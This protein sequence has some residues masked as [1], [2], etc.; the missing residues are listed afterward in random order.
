MGAEAPE[1]H[2]EKCIKQHVQ[3]VTKN[4][5]FPLNQMV[6]NQY[7]AGTVTKNIDQRDSNLKLELS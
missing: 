6:Q 2:P 5:K 7:T 3:N 4:V 1:A